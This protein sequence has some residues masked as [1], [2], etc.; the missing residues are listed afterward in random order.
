MSATALC[1][2]LAW[3]TRDW[4]DLAFHIM[5]YMACTVVVALRFGRPAWV[6]SVALSMVAYDYFFESPVLSL[7]VA[8][9]PNLIVFGS[10]LAIAQLVSSLV[11]R[12]RIQTNLAE[13]RA[14]EASTLYALSRELSKERTPE[15]IVREATSFLGRELDLPVVI[16]L[17]DAQAL[18][19][20]A[21]QIPLQGTHGI[22]GR[23]SMASEPAFEA[24]L[25]VLRSCAVPIAQALERARLALSMERAQ[26]EAEAER[27]R[28]TLLS[29]VSHDLRTPLSAIGAASAL[30]SQDG[31]L[32]SPAERR[33]LTDLITEEAFRLNHLV[34]NILEITRLDRNESEVSREWQPLEGVVGSTLTHL[35]MHRGPVPVRVKLPANLPL[36]NIDGALV[37]QLFVNLL[38]NALKY[39][40]GTEVLL[41]AELRDDG[42]MVEVRDGGP[43]VPAA[44]REHIFEKFYRPPESQKDGGIGL[45]LAI[46][47]AIVRAHEG[48]IWVEEAPGGG[49]AFRF[50]LPVARGPQLFADGL[51]S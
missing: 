26:V 9:W 11:Y 7:R 31:E 3:L 2:L 17:G 20:P 44:L 25:P 38:E 41:S 43:G 49:A 4:G 27:S 18:P 21:M 33:E 19:D 30:L 39:A 15:G 28:S 16:E 42:V 13:A 34:E 1:T 37:E 12:L 48:R 8:N 36:V 47:R 32:M 35:E 14:R 6:L 45:G 51:P 50:T 40:P 24:W 22:L 10:M 29:G 5:L 46:C 23:I